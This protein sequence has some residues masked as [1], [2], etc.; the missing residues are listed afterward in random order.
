MGYSKYRWFTKGS[1]I[2]PLR[3]D[4]PLLLRIR[5]GEF[6]LSYM[7]SEA[8]ENDR[9]AERLYKKAAD[10]Y[11]G[12]DPEAR[13]EKGREESR[14]KRIKAVK[15]R[16]EAGSH[17]W[18]MLSRLQTELVKEFGKDLWDEAMKRQRGDGSVEAL[19]QWYKMR[20]KTPQTPSEFDIRWKRFNTRGC[21]H[22]F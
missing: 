19:Y 14:M 8:V 4:A 15:L 21:E 3:S 2:K 18:R 12:D 22:L 6:N 5:N 17:E 11:K 20:T 9:L 10:S 16:L 7:F 1:P 13:H